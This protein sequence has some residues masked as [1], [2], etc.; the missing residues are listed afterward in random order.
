MSGARLTNSILRDSF[1]CSSSARGVWGVGGWGWLSG[2]LHGNYVPS[3]LILRVAKPSWKM[4]LL[5]DADAATSM[6]AG[7]GMGPVVAFHALGLLFAVD[8]T[9]PNLAPCTTCSV[10][11]LCACGLLSPIANIDAKGLSFCS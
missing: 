10:P 3:L 6:V 7:A 4:P 2:I 9:S 5:P 11:F 1:S 8:V